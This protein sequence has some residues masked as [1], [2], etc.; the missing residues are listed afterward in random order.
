MKATFN[1]QDVHCGACAK[2]ITTA[3][4]A[5]QPGADVHVEIASGLVTVRPVG[6]PGTIVKAIE[7]AGY[8]V[9]PS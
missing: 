2:R 8:P 4:H 9:K 3:I 7:G 1:V 5:V 6:D